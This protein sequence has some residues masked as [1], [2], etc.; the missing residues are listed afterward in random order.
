[1]GILYL[2]EAGNTGLWDDNQPFLIYGGP[3]VTAKQWKNVNNSIKAISGQYKAL[4]LSRFKTGIDAVSMDTMIETTDFL[5][6]FKIHSAE[7]MNGK[8]L[9]GKLTLDERYKLLDSVINTLVKEN[10]VFFAGVLNKVKYRPVKKVDTKMREYNKLVA[11][12]FTLVDSTLDENDDV[13]V[14]I[15]DGDQ[16]EKDIV[17]KEIGKQANDRFLGELYVEKSASMPLLQAADVGIW[18][19]QAHHKLTS[20]LG[21][22]VKQNKEVTALFEKLKPLLREVVIER[23]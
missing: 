18:V 23:A 4:I 17:K 13:V 21:L 20:G 19:L 22:K 7:V 16:V 9:W 5:R 11:E 2:D 8:G 3:Y 14:T 10:V 15:D 1:M 12:L 6:E